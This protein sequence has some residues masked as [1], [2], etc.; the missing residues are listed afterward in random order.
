MHTRGHTKQGGGVG[1]GDGGVT[2]IGFF[3]RMNTYIRVNTQTT[4]ALRGEFVLLTF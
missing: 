3:T 4:K 2:Y 1:G